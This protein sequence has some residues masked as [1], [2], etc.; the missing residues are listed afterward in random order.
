MTYEEQGHA[1]HCIDTLREEIMCNADDTPV[2]TFKN[3]KHPFGY[4]QY[5]MCREWAP[6]RDWASQYSICYASSTQ[7]L[8]GQ[9]AF[10][11]CDGGHDNIIIP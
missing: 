6:L 5:R 7:R 11:R 2:A 3:H 9:G 1:Y 4:Q 10:D 8:P